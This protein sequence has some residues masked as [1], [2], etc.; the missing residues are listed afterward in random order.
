MCYTD[1]VPCLKTIKTKKIS[2]SGKQNVVFIVYILW[3]GLDYLDERKEKCMKKIGMLLALC[4]CLSLV[5]LPALA[6]QGDAAMFLSNNSI[7]DCQVRAVHAEGDT[8]YLVKGDTDNV[9]SYYSYRVGDAE[10][11]LIMEGKIEYPQSE[12]DQPFRVHKVFFAD[13]AFYALNTQT[14]LLLKLAAENGKPVVAQAVTLDLS[15]FQ[16]TETYEDQEYTYTLELQSWTAMGNKLFVCLRDYNYGDGEPQLAML[17]MTTG[18]KT[19]DNVSFVRLFTPYQDG[20]L[21]CMVVDDNNMYDID[22]GKYKPIPFSVFDPETDTLEPLFEIPYMTYYDISAM[23]YDAENNWLYLACPE[24]IYRVDCAT[25][26]FVLSA[27]VPCSYYQDYRGSAIARVGAHVMVLGSNGVYVRL[28]D[29]AQL[30]KD[31]LTIYNGYSDDAHTRAIAQMDDIPVTFFDKAYY[32]TAQELGQAMVSGENEIDI[33]HVSLS[34]MDFQRLMEKGYCYDLSG[35]EKLSA[36]A[37]Q[38]YPV[39]SKEITLDGKLYG[40]PVDFYVST[41]SVSS[42]LEKKLKLEC[43]KTLVELC[44]FLN[45]WAEKGYYEEYTDYQPFEEGELRNMVIS[46]ALSMYIDYMQ[47]TGQTLKLDTPEFREIMTAAAAV[48]VSDYEIQVN[49]EDDDSV[50]ELF[51]KSGLFRNY[52]YLSVRYNMRFSQD[53]DYDTYSPMLLTLTENTPLCL[54]AQVEVMFINPRSKHLDAALRYLELYM[55]NIEPSMLAMMCPDKNDPIENPHF[56]ETVKIYRNNID[57]IKKALETCKEEDK[58]AYQE[59]LEN[60]EGYYKDWEREGKYSATAES[61]AAY[62]AYDSYFFVRKPNAFYSSGSDDSLSNLLSR[63]L[64]GQLP[65]EQFIQ[66]FDAKLRLM[67]NE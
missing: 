2:R 36:L 38:F 64:D 9:L 15:D 18:E 32:A 65:L 55:E 45:D 50:N 34:Y 58:A 31:A 47:A 26:E 12:T 63:F 33:F 29:P 57:R 46:Q 7:Y 1:I 3:K 10:P 30:P 28:A 11:T 27:Y 8:F 16:Y 20:K 62:R 39:L 42:A 49:W 60:Y 66:E 23:T 19:G 14:G 22:S 43:P 6:A 40:M 61:I 25:G 21:L 44:Q 13:G 52:Q 24:R 56:E 67:Q 17:D 54:S 37:A 48:D 5:A 4:L 41:W 59:Q 51:N 35:S 53:E